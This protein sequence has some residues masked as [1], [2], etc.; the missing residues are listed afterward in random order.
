MKYQSRL[1]RNS[2]NIASCFLIG[3]YDFGNPPK[4]AL[5]G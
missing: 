5:I 1:T 2:Q 3:C 4:L